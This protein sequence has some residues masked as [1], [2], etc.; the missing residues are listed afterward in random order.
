[1]NFT[2]VLT[3]QGACSLICGSGCHL[4]ELREIFCKKLTSDN[5]ATRNTEAPLCD[6]Y[7]GPGCPARG[8]RNM[9]AL[10]SFIHSNYAC[11]SLWRSNV[12]ASFRHQLGEILGHQTSRSLAGGVGVARSKG[13]WA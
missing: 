1:M 10:A 13:P 3:V 9:A 2:S 8:G 6:I 12:P 5:R 7:F 11:L 4:R